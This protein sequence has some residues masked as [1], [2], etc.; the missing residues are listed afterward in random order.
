MKIKTALGLCNFVSLILLTV[1]L[2]IVYKVSADNFMIASIIAVGGLSLFTIITRTIVYNSI[3]G[4]SLKEINTLLDEI[5]EGNFKKRFNVSSKNELGGVQENFNDF[6]DKFENIIL[7]MHEVSGK[8]ANNSSELDNNLHSIVKANSDLSIRGIKES[9]ETIVNMVTSQ[10]AETEEIFASLTEISSMIGSV[11][12]N[13]GNT[14]QI[15]KETTEL[16]K[17]GGKKVA[18]SLQGMIE[19]QNTVKNIEEKAHNLGETSSKV[20]QIVGIIGGISEQTNLLALNAAIEAARAGEAGRG[21]AV[22]AD[23]VRKLAENSRHSTE[24]ISA[25]IS[26]IQKEVYEVIIAVNNGY[27][28]SKEGRVLAEETYK[29]IETII[30]KVQ[31]TDGR[32]EEITT[33][34]KEQAIATNEINSTME[35]IA[36][37]STEINHVAMTHNEALDSVSGNLNESLKNLKVISVVSEALKNLVQTFSVDTNKKA[38]EVDAI[39]WKSEYNIKVK[40]IDDQHKVLVDLMN[41]LNNAMLHEK[42]KNEIGRII[43][44]LVDYTEFHFDYEESLLKKYGY[45]DFDNHK[46]LH[47]KFVDQIKN[48]QKEFQSGEKEM[49]KEVMDFL[50]NWLIQHIMGTDTKYSELLQKNKQN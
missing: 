40:S 4:K 44:G 36:T 8:L 45:P 38:V 48:V 18:E 14:K 29:N 25:L 11:S 37:N 6:L 1:I 7:N 50:K 49:S 33:A 16:A 32:M 21:F 19:I 47:V 42:G 13:I 5:K 23:E 43:K 31:I 3:I 9:M 17:L 24:Q 2:N 20:G 12:E 34:M 15:S 10:T 39:P 27:E 35:S 28:K 41:D 26:I 22:V 46:K 30:E